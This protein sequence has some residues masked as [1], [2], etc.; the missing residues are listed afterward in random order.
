MDGV[1]SADAT[2]RWRSMPQDEIVRVVG[3]ADSLW[4]YA[5]NPFG[6]INRRFSIF[7]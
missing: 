7:H 4:F 1:R 3:P 5:T 6:P 2:L